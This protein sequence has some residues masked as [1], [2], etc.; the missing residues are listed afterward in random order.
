MPLTPNERRSL[1]Y[2]T[3]ISI[4]ITAAAASAAP[5][6]W[7]PFL[8]TIGAEPE[9]AALAGGCSGY[10]L[11]AQNRWAPTGAAVRVAPG[12]DAKKVNGFAG[13]EVV[14]VD[15]WVHGKVALPTNTAPW[16]SDI[17]FHL[18]D[19]S[20]WVSFPGLRSA[21]NSTDPTGRSPDGGIPPATP[22]DCQGHVA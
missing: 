13:N 7:H 8:R 10:Q 16:N 17:W 6:W 20:G 5:F 4:V 19:G 3:I 12:P 2:G 14:T 11:Y 22:P 15:G 1:V 9:V 21:P 18:S